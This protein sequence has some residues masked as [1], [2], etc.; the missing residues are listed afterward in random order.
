MRVRRF[1]SSVY[2]SRRHRR[3]LKPSGIM[4]TVWWHSSSTF[5][6]PFAAFFP[7]LLCR[8][9]AAFEKHS[10]RCSI[11]PSRPIADD[12]QLS[13]LHDFLTSVPSIISNMYKRLQ[14]YMG[15]APF[16]FQRVLQRNNPRR[17]KWTMF[18]EYWW[19]SLLLVSFPIVPRL[20]TAAV[21]KLQKVTRIDYEA[22][23]AIFSSTNRCREKCFK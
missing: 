15:E 14:R 22:I 8:V 10:L 2:N 18:L 19:P 1:F 9:Y 12:A 3:R 16:I 21:V 20:Q 7:S 13:S 23:R 4:R 17:R 6:L 5:P 11:F